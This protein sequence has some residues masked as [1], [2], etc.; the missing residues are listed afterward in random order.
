MITE[1]K[2]KKRSAWEWIRQE[3]ILLILILFFCYYAWSRLLPPYVAPDEGMRFQIPNFIYENGYLPHGAD[4]A[5][6]DSMWG[7]SYG[8]TPILPQIIGAGFMK[9][10]SLFTT[11]GFSLLMAA[12]MVSILSA[13]ATSWFAIKISERLFQG[14]MRWVFVIL[15]ALL[16][17]FM[18]LGAYINNDCFAIFSSSIIFYAW[19]IGLQENWPVKSCIMLG[20]G[21]GLCAMSYYNAYGWLL[22]SVVL[23]FVS[24]IMIDREKWS[25]RAFRK[26]VYLIAALFLA[27]AAWWFIRSYIIYDGDFLGLNI[28]EHY[29]ELY[30]I[31]DLKPSHYQTVADQGISLVSMLISMNWLALTFCSAVGLFGSMDIFLPIWIYAAYAALFLA[32]FIG[33]LIRFVGF[34]KNK[35]EKRSGKK[36]L[37]GICMLFTMIIP[38]ILSMYYSYASDFQPQGR[39]VLS[40]LIPFMVFVVLGL[41]TLAKKLIRKK[42]IR[43]TAAICLCGVLVLLTVWAF[44]GTYVQTYLP[45]MPL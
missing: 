41:E 21:M 19:V 24:A 17:Q 40:M 37:L 34:I 9:I 11:D 18:F 33:M 39:Y 32:G 43:K 6:R 22:M 42:Q 14:M 44:A 4:P 3:H 28:S 31:D 1:K 2:L 5:I 27:I 16:P 20:I 30:A 15:V 38:V 36:W 26:K 25:H 12:R 13:T 7:I 29:K 8:F 45:H 35:K 23:F 10:A